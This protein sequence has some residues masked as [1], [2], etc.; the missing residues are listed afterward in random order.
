MSKKL[1]PKFY[2]I[3]EGKGVKNKIVT[4]W[5]ECKEL[6]HGYPSVY[7]SFLTKEEAEKY[8]G[9]IK[10]TQLPELKEK[11]KKNIEYSKKKKA[12]TKPLNLRISS[13]VLDDFMKRL[14]EENLDKNKIITEMI[15]EWL[16]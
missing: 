9:S 3:K 1:K 10:E 4:T 6:V 14:D 15:K 8:L 13:D 2:A 11:I 12:T 16:Y 5:N 7:K